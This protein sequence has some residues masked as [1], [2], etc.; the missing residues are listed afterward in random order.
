MP[1]IIIDSIQT[2]SNKEESGNFPLS[3]R[4]RNNSISSQSSVGSQSVLPQ[5]YERMLTKKL[6][7]KLREVV[8]GEQKR[9]KG[10]KVQKYLTT[11]LLKAANSI[12]DVLDIRISHKKPKAEASA[13]TDN[14]EQFTEIK[15]YQSVNKPQKGPSYAEIA[16]KR[17]KR[18]ATIL[19]YPKEEKPNTN[20][21]DRLKKELQQSET[22][23]KIKSV[24]RIQK[25]GLAI[26]CKREEDLQKLT[27]T[28]KEKET[29]TENITAKRTG[30]RHPSIIIYNVPDNV[31]MED[32]QKA[33]RAHTKYSEDLKLRFKMRGRTE[34]TSHLI[35]EAPS[36]TFHRLKN[37]RRIAINW[38]MFHLKEFHHVKRCSTCQA[39]THTANSGQCKNDIP[40]CGRCSV[41]HHTWKCM[42]NEHFCINCSES[43]KL[44]GTNLHI[45]HMAID[46]RCP[47][48]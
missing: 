27:E 35:L 47:F 6:L 1:E 48:Y 34:D 23:V 41:R 28:L 10:N 45:Y 16:R 24:W 8:N 13:Q 33:I 22:A 14:A 43:N 12:L 18:K 4:Q 29:I 31:P 7:L 3:M 36:E 21:E 19:I 5:T 38:E 15:S 25:G 46:P 32:V 2:C 26:T 17:P 39:F 20:A 42:S 44:N 40:F 37:L 9:K 30:M 11:S